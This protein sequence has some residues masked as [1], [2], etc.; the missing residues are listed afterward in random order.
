MDAPLLSSSSAV[1]TSSTKE[2]GQQVVRRLPSLDDD[3]ADLFDSARRRAA[4]ITRRTD[5]F[6]L[7]LAEPDGRIENGVR[8]MGAPKS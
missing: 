1:A 6:V 8:A 5:L 3:P 7:T 2:G 4:P